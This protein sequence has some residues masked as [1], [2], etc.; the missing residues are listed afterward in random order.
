M[1]GTEEPVECTYY[2]GEL[3][4]HSAGLYFLLFPYIRTATVHV[5]EGRCATYLCIFMQ[6][7]IL[8]LKIQVTAVVVA[9]VC[10]FFFI[11]ME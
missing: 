5:Q 9:S 7:N 8:P 10:T 11:T 2:F 1:S 4:L 6:C 3:H